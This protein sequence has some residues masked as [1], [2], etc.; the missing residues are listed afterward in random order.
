MNKQLDIYNLIGEIIKAKGKL[1]MVKFVLE[2][3]GELPSDVRSAFSVIN[4]YLKQKIYEDE[5]KDVP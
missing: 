1:E 5:L 3:M 2:L 4:Q